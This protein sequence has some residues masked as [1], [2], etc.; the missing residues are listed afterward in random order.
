[1]NRRI[2]IILSAHLLVLITILAGIVSCTVKQPPVPEDESVVKTGGEQ[3]IEDHLGELDGMRVGLVMNPT[4]V[5][6]G[7]HMLDTLMAHN[8]NITALFAP[9]HGFR[10][11]RSVGRCASD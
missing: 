9:E 8:I 7:V 1:M 2:S 5:V 6:N 10:G 3:L 11:E 4:A